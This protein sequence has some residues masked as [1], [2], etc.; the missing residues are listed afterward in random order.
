MYSYNLMDKFRA[1]LICAALGAT[2]AVSSFLAAQDQSDVS[3]GIA[4]SHLLKH[5]D[6]VY[7]GFAKAAGLEGVVRIHVA[8]TER[9]RIGTIEIRSGPPSLWTAATDCVLQNV[10]QPFEKDGHP[11]GVTTTLDVVFKL[12]S[13]KGA[14]ILDPAPKITRKDLTWASRSSPSRNVSVALR[15]WIATDLDDKQKQMYCDDPE[16]NLLREQ[17]RD[18]NGEIPS[19]IKIFELAE[20][21]SGAKVYLIRP[22]LQAMCGATGNC[23]IQLVEENSSGIHCFAELYGGGYF[24][25]PNSRSEFPNIFIASNSGGGI[26]GVAGYSNIGGAWGQLYCGQITNGDDGEKSE[27]SICH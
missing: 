25:S 21:R 2:F 26:I 20:N 16:C 7:P 15:K 4:A 17:L 22:Q 11:V 8:I 18:L 1:Y 27:N 13:R 12:A 24:L 6:P 3:P 5:V 23:D 9:G 10:Y 14:P 19:E